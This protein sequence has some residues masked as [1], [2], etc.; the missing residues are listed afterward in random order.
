MTEPWKGAAHRAVADDFVRAAE[1][2]G[3]EVAAIRA[4]WAVEAAGSPY[5]PD[6]SLQR[7]FEP[8]KLRVPIGDYR[9]SLRLTAARREA[10]FQ[11]A[12]ARDP[13]DALRAT[14]WGGPQIMG[15]NASAAG[16]ITAL[17]MVRAMAESE[18]EQVTAFTT[19]ILSWGLDSA[20]RAHDWR[21]FAARYNGSGNVAEYATSIETAYQEISGQAS[22][23]VLRAGARGEAVRRLQLALGV[24]PDGAFGPETEAAVRIFQGQSGLPVD[25]IVGAR[26]WAALARRRDAQPIRQPA[27][28]DRLAQITKVSAAAGGLASAVAAIGDALP[29]STLNILVGGG[30]ILG[31]IA[32]ALWAFQRSRWVA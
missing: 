6:G 12:Y 15:F 1:R 10:L 24:E 11:Q 22:P 25:G 32:V 20:L 27:R 4:V 17:G 29:E 21:T 8:H 30:M 14:S 26:T 19:L 31:L 3:C 5:R 13:E 7:R 23:V 28:E 2:I 9:S 16:Y 18:A